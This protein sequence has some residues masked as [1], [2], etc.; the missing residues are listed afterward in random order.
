MSH[1]R[2]VLWSCLLS[3]VLTTRVYAENNQWT[4]GRSVLSFK[5]SEDVW[6]HFGDYRIALSMGVPVSARLPCTATEEGFVGNC[7]VRHNRDRSMTWV[8]FFQ[9]ERLIFIRIIDSDR[10]TRVRHDLEHIL[11]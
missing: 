5:M 11:V 2:L 4:L 10:G 3:G 8:F 1:A 7:L 6:I 9:G